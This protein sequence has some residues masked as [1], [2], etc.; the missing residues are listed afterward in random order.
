MLRIAPCAELISDIQAAVHKLLHICI[1]MYADTMGV[2]QCF[3][4]QWRAA[5][6]WTWAVGLVETASSS[7]NW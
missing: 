2:V 3:L 6:W 5:G 1:R 4:K 7:A